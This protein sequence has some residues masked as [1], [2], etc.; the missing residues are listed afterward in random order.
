VPAASAA[1]T[2]FLPPRLLKKGLDSHTVAG[3]TIA[4]S[5]RKRIYAEGPYVQDRRIFKT[6]QDQHP[7]A[8]PLRRDR[9]A[10]AGGDRPLDRLSPVRGLPADDRQ[11]HH[12]PAVSGV[13]PGGDGI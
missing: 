3:R 4:V 1:G 13:L 8:A 10:G 12:R 5:S 6:V 11:P 2:F 9:P 7:D